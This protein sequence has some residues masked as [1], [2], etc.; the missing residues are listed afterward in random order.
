MNNIKQ[1]IFL[2]LISIAI[3]SINYHSVKN[4]AYTSTATRDYTVNTFLGINDSIQSKKIENF[5]KGRIVSCK[6]AGFVCNS[7]GIN[8][9][10][11]NDARVKYRDNPH[12]ETIAGTEYRIER[13]RLAE[14]CGYISS[15]LLFVSFLIL[16]CFAKNPLLCISCVGIGLQYAWLPIG[17]YLVLPWDAWVPL[18]FLIVLLIAESKNKKLIIFLIP[19]FSLFKESII[20]LSILI[21]F[22]DGTLKKRIIT[23]C[24]VVA[25]VMIIK[26]VIADIAMV[27]IVNS[28][29]KYQHVCKTGELFKIIRNI[30]IRAIS[31]HLFSNKNQTQNGNHPL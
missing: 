22:F 2:I 13:M 12:D 19:A 28:E 14:C 5:W 9:D 17:E 18:M 26:W 25:A 8:Y 24:L 20:V 11:Y 21:L 1:N 16:I 6:I 30:Q 3:C 27:G 10:N 29:L 7:F 23:F 31:L 4:S 15:A